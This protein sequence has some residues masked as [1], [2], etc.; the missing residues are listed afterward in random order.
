MAN[1]RR[2][3]VVCVDC[4]YLRERPSGISTLVQAVVDHVPAMAPD[5][6]FVFMKHPRGPERLSAAPNVREVVV[7]AEANGPGTMFWFPRLVDLRSIDLYHNTFNVMPYGLARR[8]VRSVITVTDIMQLKHPRLAKG[9]GLLGWADVVYKWHGIK[10]A[11]AHATRILTISDATRQEIATVDAAAAAKTIVAFEGIS[12]DFHALDGVEGA[13]EIESVRRRFC[14]GA[15]RYVL[16]VGQFSAYKNHEGVLRAFAKAFAAEPDV[17]MVFVQRLG[18]GPKVL[19]PIA[20]ELGVDARVHFARDL[21]VGE[22]NAIYNGA[23][24]LCHPSFYE[25]FGNP[26]AEAMAAGCPVV[27]SNRSSMPEVAAGAAQ[28]VDPDRNDDVAAALRRIATEPEL[29]ASMRARGLARAAELS[30]KNFAAKNLE[31]YREA[32][33][34]PAP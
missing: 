12:P 14:A 25:G 16:T 31:A 13:R 29:A 5:L 23:I 3:P 8:S 24:A 27:T 17:H 21:S 28:L 32:L 26:P 4:R 10:R 19:R 11:F 34:A 1:S 7:S 15:P 20:R 18:V 2:A 6:E 9:P 33:A 30:W 22:L